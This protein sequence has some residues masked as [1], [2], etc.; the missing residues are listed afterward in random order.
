MILI[1]DEINDEQNENSQL[2]NKNSNI[3]FHSYINKVSSI[4]QKLEIAEKKYARRMRGL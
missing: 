2:N 1:I 4:I 3:N